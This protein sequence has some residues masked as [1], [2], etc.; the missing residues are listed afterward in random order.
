MSRPSSLT[1][2]FC[3]SRKSSKGKLVKNMDHGQRHGEVTG[4]R[5]SDVWQAGRDS[6]E[7]MDRWGRPMRQKREGNIKWDRRPVGQTDRGTDRWRNQTDCWTS[8]IQEMDK[9][10]RCTEKRTSSWCPWRRPKSTH[11]HPRMPLL[12]DTSNGRTHLLGGHV[13]WEDTS[14]GRTRLPKRHV[15]KEDTSSGRTRV[16]RTFL[17]GDLVI[18]RNGAEEE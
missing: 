9:A 1:L 2:T 8:D 6:P 7:K 5:R 18:S 4:T 12:E 17:S 13:Y 11:F 3:F 15:A 10:D 16:C 14:T